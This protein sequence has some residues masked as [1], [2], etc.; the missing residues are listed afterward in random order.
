MSTE[1]AENK[2]FSLVGLC[3]LLT[4]TSGAAESQQADPAQEVRETEAA[5]A[6]TMTNRDLAAFS[7]FI[8]ADAVFLAGEQPLRGK[9]QVVEGWKRLYERSATSFLRE[10]QDIELLDSG[11]LARSSGPV[12]DADGKLI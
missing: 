4:R 1:H 2:T 8:A 6:K 9:S 7:R 11:R 3:R 10:P 5:F 12:H